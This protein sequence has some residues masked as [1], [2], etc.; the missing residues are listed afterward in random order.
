M[1]SANSQ[2]SPNENVSAHKASPPTNQHQNQQQQ[3][4]LLRLLAQH[5][6]YQFYQIAGNSSTN[7]HDLGGLERLAA[8]TGDQSQF[9]TGTANYHLNGGSSGRQDEVSAVVNN[10]SRQLDSLLQSNPISNSH[11]LQALS[12]SQ[13]QVHHTNQQLHHQLQPIRVAHSNEQQQQ[14]LTTSSL[15]LERYH[16]GNTNNHPHADRANNNLSSSGASMN[17][18]DSLGLN[19]TSNQ[20]VLSLQ[21]QQQQSLLQ[22]AAAAETARQQYESNS[23]LSTRLDTDYHHLIASNVA[24][25]VRQHQLSNQNILHHHLPVREFQSSVADGGKEDTLKFSINTILGSQP[26]PRSTS[27]TVGQRGEEVHPKTSKNKSRPKKENIGDQESDDN[28]S[29]VANEEVDHTNNGYDRDSDCDPI[30]EL[31]NQS[32]SP[33]S[34]GLAGIQTPI[35]KNSSS[36]TKNSLLTFANTSPLV[37][38]QDHHRSAT[39]LTINNNQPPLQFPVDISALHHHQ[40]QQQHQANQLF[41]QSQNH[42]HPALPFLGGPTTFPWTV[43]TRGKPRRGMMRRAVF[44]DSQRVGL[45]KKF[46]LQKYISKPDRK[47]LAEKL[48]LR[49]SQVKIWFQNRRMK[50]RNSKERELLSAGGSRDQTL[51]TRNNPNPDLSDVGETVKRLTGSQTKSDDPKVTSPVVVVE[52]DQT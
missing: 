10:P 11:S 31:S 34:E 21:Q 37:T 39:N 24:N 8:A 44:S 23:R 1:A 14:Q 2:E 51:P 38:S 15:A 32:L 28:D 46:T 9:L 6:Q 47:K 17:L 20:F 25:L 52:S 22:A 19:L 29:N 33:T 12:R 40:Q 35:N 18:L 42:G 13:H 48:G 45:E 30:G 49:D 26:S 5:F 7:P 16:N 36:N 43:A 41:R 3:A 50:W 27:A 4:E